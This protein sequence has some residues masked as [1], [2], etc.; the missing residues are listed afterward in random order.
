M[1]YIHITLFTIFTSIGAERFSSKAFIGSVNKCLFGAG[2]ELYF[3]P[4]TGHKQLLV[5]SENNYTVLKALQYTY[6]NGQGNKHDL[7]RHSDNY[8]KW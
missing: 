1:C 6:S 2:F 7:I 8:R 3:A 5:P 4:A